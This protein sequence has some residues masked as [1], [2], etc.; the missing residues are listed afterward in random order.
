[1]NLLHENHW[2]SRTELL[3]GKEKLLKLQKAHVLVVG[4]G[5]VGAMAAEQLARAGIGELTIADSDRLCLT[6]INRQLLALHSTIKKN[7]TEVLAERLKDIN[8]E[9]KLH[10]V[11]SYLKDD[12][13]KELVSKSYDFVVD[14]ID[15]LSPK[16]Y[17][18]FHALR[19][20]QRLVSSMGAGAKLDPTKIHISDFSE[21]HSCHLAFHLRKRLKKLEI[22]TGF[23][24]VFSSEKIIK[25]ALVHV[26]DERNKKTNVGTISYMPAIFGCY[27]ASVVIN[28]LIEK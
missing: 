5:G 18:I 9:I 14:A 20:N 17:L 3:I 23:K 10:I 19:N 11:N 7:K 21:T 22:T 4:L 13:L 1:M 28:D 25:E 16:I 8:P 24:V 15:T 26:E 6:N 2:Q 27:C 12:S